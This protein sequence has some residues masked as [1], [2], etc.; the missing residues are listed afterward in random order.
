MKAKDLMEALGDVPETLVRAG[1]EP[2]AEPETSA[3]E[4]QTD[5][6]QQERRIS[7]VMRKVSAGTAIAACVAVVAGFV[8]IIGRMNDKGQTVTPK[9]AGESIAT[10]P[11]KP[12][13]AGAGEQVYSPITQQQTGEEAGGIPFTV[14]ESDSC[15]TGLMLKDT[16]VRSD[17]ELKGLRSKV[18]ADLKY[19][20]NP[21]FWNDN[22]MLFIYKEFSTWT[23]NTEKL[24]QIQSITPLTEECWPPRD[25]IWVNAV[26]ETGGVTGAALQGWYCLIAVP[27]DR[28]PNTPDAE[29]LY[30]KLSVTE[31][32][33]SVV[34]AEHIDW[35][36]GQIY[37][38][39]DR[40]EGDAGNI[41]STRTLSCFPG[42]E[43][44][45]SSSEAPSVEDIVSVYSADQLISGGGGNPV[46]NAYFADLNGD[47]APELCITY[48][49]SALDH[50]YNMVTIFD[51]KSQ[52]ETN[53]KQIYMLP[54]E[55]GTWSSEK[56]E[57]S[58]TLF[59]DGQGRLL[60][61]RQPISEAPLNPDK[62]Y[63]E[64]VE[65]RFENGLLYLH[66][67]GMPSM[68][69]TPP[70]EPMQTVSMTTQTTAVT[71]TTEPTT[72]TASAAY[73]PPK[74]QT[75]FSG[76][77]VMWFDQILYRTQ[78]IP[79]VYRLNEY[80]DLAFQRQS[81]DTIV[82]A[83]HGTILYTLSG[84]PIWN[85]YFADISGDGSPEFCATVS[86]GSGMIDERVIVYDI[87]N[88]KEYT[89]A[90]RCKTNYVLSM[91][92]GTLG[93]RKSVYPATP[94]DRASNY[95][96]GALVLENGRLSVVPITEDGSQS[97][98]RS[99]S[100]LL[101]QLEFKPI[102]CDGIP[103][104]T[105]TAPDGSVFYLHL[106]GNTPYVWK[107]GMGDMEAL[108]PKDLVEKIL[109]LQQMIGLKEFTDYS[110]LHL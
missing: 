10:E 101:N 42:I 13:S 55:S 43:F 26:R 91:E 53:K 64:Q 66:S 108:L 75:S 19:D 32:D 100:N 84:M 35:Q 3:A 7:A 62:L 25:V 23:E 12:D 44:R 73:E 48:R 31:L 50:G 29:G 54:D 17:S 93:V 22:V 51:I 33:R 56:D 49:T 99:I 68:Q 110:D 9:K 95:Q 61:R 57:N 20:D 2:P 4:Q 94:L 15:S 41:E 21:A 96:P 90:D 24:P 30:V 86:F 52:M 59:R 76:K 36:P 58:Y 81:E 5:N 45:L 88:G 72:T 60:L 71:D 34:P 40:L 105:L 65:M 63:Q 83:E 16:V 39:F 18:G 104:Y 69:T 102:T 103:E 1:L 37:K 109:G 78:D 67:L 82:L 28:I 97:W 98:I 106:S 27:A 11:A 107:E 79:V 47:D 92:F 6:T 77:P 46:L 14:T 80:Q 70:Q 87:L 38:W 74:Q 85:A 89:L 8:W